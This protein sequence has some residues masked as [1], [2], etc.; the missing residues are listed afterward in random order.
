[1]QKRKVYQVLAHLVAWNPPVSIADERARQIREA[2]DMLPSGSGWDCGTKLDESKSTPQ[3]LVLYGSYHHMN[4]GGYYDGWS[5]HT[6]VVTP[7]LAQG[8]Q[9]K[10]T[11]RDR[12]DIKEYLYDLFYEALAQDEPEQEPTA[13]AKVG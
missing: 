9:I 8:F 5:E 10:I 2:L 13:I 3:K 6:I 1:M 4:D 11:G 7:H 12:N